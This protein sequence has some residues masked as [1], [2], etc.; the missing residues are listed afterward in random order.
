MGVEVYVSPSSP[1]PGQT[2]KCYWRYENTWTK[3]YQFK[4]EFYLDERLI[5]TVNL[6][7]LY[8]GQSKEGSFSFT[9]PSSTGTHKL[10]AISYLYTYGQWVNDDEATATFMVGKI[11]MTTILMS[12]LKKWYKNN[13]GISGADWSFNVTEMVKKVYPDVTKA[14]LY[15]WYRIEGYTYAG[16]ERPPDRDPRDIV[17]GWE[18]GIELALFN[19]GTD[20]YNI[21]E[22]YAGW[23]WVTVPCRLEIKRAEPKADIQY[24]KVNGESVGKGESKTVSKADIAIDVGVKNTG[25]SGN[26]TVNVSIESSDLSWGTGDT[27]IVGIN[28]GEV[29][30]VTFNKT[31]PKAGEYRVTIRVGH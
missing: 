19:I 8:S 12:E 18:D 2:V 25:G 7:Y 11:D 22:E 21:P 3:G 23:Y 30:K 31:L 28:A 6:G 4:I 15:G 13:L 1:E 29:K 9:A 14:T 24:V 16:K 5:K 10:K 17:K 20:V 27:K 26:I